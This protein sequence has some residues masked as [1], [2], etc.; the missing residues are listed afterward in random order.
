MFVSHS[1]FFPN[2][3][4][5]KL[6]T[7]KVL[8]VSE[9]NLIPK[10]P[11]FD[12]KNHSSDISFNYFQF[13]PHLFSFWILIHNQSSPSLSKFGCIWL[14][15]ISLHNCVSFHPSPFLIASAVVLDLIGRHSL[16]YSSS[17]L[18]LFSHSILTFSSIWIIIWSILC[19]HFINANHAL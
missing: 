8:Q 3:P 17:D 16:I 11:L 4:M 7:M 12:T 10:Y 5:S 6:K 15:I 2:I 19:V 9:C 18:L 1:F 13:Y 14:A